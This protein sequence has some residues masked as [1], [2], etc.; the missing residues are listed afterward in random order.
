M[1]EEQEAEEGKEEGG[2]DGESNSVNAARGVRREH[3]GETAGGEDG[4]RRSGP[5]T[6]AELESSE[7]VRALLEGLQVGGR[8]AFSTSLTSEE[9]RI[10]HEIADGVGG[11]VHESKGKG[12]RRRIVVSRS[13]A[14]HSSTPSDAQV[15]GLYL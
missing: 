15:S 14:P 5:S 11:L 6:V 2:G 13:R 10:V 1:L 4:I 8:Q 3:T 7:Q 12:I 9:R